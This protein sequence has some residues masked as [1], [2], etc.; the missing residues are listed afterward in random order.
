MLFESR[1]RPATFLRI[2]GL[3]KKY[4]FDR[5]FAFMIDGCASDSLGVMESV[6]G[7]RRAPVVKRRFSGR[8]KITD[9]SRF[10]PDADS[11]ARGLGRTG[12]IRATSPARKPRG[13]H[14]AEYVVEKH[15]SANN[16]SRNRHFDQK[17]SICITFLLSCSVAKFEIARE[18][19]ACSQVVSPGGTGIGLVLEM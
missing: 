14:P 4:S 8:H 1:N 12:G 9:G 16:F 7:L 6:A 19:S 5:F 18:F 15:H 3:P 11:W 13:M 10:Q 17:V 2:A